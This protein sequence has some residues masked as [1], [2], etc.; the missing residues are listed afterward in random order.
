MNFTTLAA[1]FFGMM[2]GASLSGLLALLYVYAT[3][4]PK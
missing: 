4:V 1:F 2:A 3:A